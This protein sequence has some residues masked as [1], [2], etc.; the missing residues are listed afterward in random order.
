M[1]T[2]HHLERSASERVIWLLE[3]L[4]LPYHVKRYQREPTLLAPAEYKA[5]HPIGAAPV[6]EDGG[7][8]LAESGAIVQYVLGRH[9]NGRLTLEPGDPQFSS[10]LYWFH[11]A[12]GTLQ[13]SLVRA[14]MFRTLKL[15]AS[16][17][18]A[19]NLSLRLNAAI[20]YIDAS[21]SRGLYFAGERFSAADIMMVFSLTTMRLY[22][23]IELGPYPHILAY[24]QRIGARPA[25][26]RAMTVANPDLTPLL[27]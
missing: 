27:T 15:E 16:D 4:E 24:L 12:N 14:F 10:F 11:F 8:V 18:V 7:T 9:G 5:L 25:Y 17:A 19:K 1:L 13:P 2:V 6:V 22:Q 20:A 21:L 3:E 23:P 26:R